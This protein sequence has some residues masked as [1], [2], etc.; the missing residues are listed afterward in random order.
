MSEVSIAGSRRDIGPLAQ[1]AFLVLVLLT[2]WFLIHARGVGEVVIAGL[3]IFA[4]LRIIVHGEWHALRRPWM[5]LALGYWAWLSI[6][7][8]L[9]DPERA[10]LLQAL[11]WLRFPLAAL[12]LAVWILTDAR[13][14]LLLAVSLALA[15]LWIAVEVW[16]QAF[17]GRGLSGPSADVPGIL[18]GPFTWARAGPFLA[19]AMWPG[20]VLAHDRL[21]QHGAVSGQAVGMAVVLGLFLMMCGALVFTGQRMPVLQTAAIVAV[22]A[23]LVPSL[24][25]PA[26]FGALAMIGLLMLTS[27]V[28]PGAFHRLA[29]DLPH[30]MASFPGGPYG[31]VWGVWLESARERP[32]TG[33]GHLA[34][35]GV[36]CPNGSTGC[37]PHSHYLQALVEGG[38]PGL[39]LFVGMSGSAL[40]AAITAW[41]TDRDPI[42]LGAWLGLLAA[43]L[44]VPA[45]K[46]MTVMPQ[47]GLLVLLAGLALGRT[48]GVGGQ[49]RDRGGLVPE[50]GAGR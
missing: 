46:A 41:R 39:V 10:D 25:R 9:G 16:L 8:A 50:G 44:S 11:A 34:W 14:R 45:L 31:E 3:A 27:V 43:G 24:R 15:C 29:I 38:L 47:I 32:W 13:A 37:H 17:L 40:W 23:V 35:Q 48:P 7:T 19:V 1:R 49:G 4:I 42:R 18:T 21:T 30:Q 12:A 2:P 6:A 5:A 22:A 26:M 33:L 28:A 20:L 36:V